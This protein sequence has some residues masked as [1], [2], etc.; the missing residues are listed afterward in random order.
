MVLVGANTTSNQCCDDRDLMLLALCG[1]MRTL[2]S[3]VQVSGPHVKSELVLRP[4]AG[5]NNSI[6]LVLQER[7]D[8]TSSDPWARICLRC[9]LLAIRPHPPRTAQ[10]P[11][12]RR[13]TR[14]ELEATFANFRRLPRARR[15][16][17]PEVA[18]HRGYAGDGTDVSAFESGMLCMLVCV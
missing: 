12:P 11:G 14:E 8:Q 9:F 5:L 1:W 10:V 17:T 3:P 2:T 13:S 16:C 15:P 18:F 6:T 4:H 7:S